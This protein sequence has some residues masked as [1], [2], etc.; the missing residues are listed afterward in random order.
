M[1]AIKL[2]YGRNL[3]DEFELNLFH[4]ALTKPFE[5][6]VENP[7][8]LSRKTEEAIAICTKAI[9]GKYLSVVS[10]SKG[11][12]LVGEEKNRL[13][14][15]K[16]L[17]RYITKKMH[18]PTIQR[19]IWDNLHK[20]WSLMPNERSRNYPSQLKKYQFL[21]AVTVFDLVL[22]EQLITSTAKTAL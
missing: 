20:I 16:E 10:Y 11:A 15:L 4:P 21:E 17:K 19:P 2:T 12:Y 8:R 22:I 7:A 5:I 13:E 6:V 14:E 9:L 1:E 3:M 18:L